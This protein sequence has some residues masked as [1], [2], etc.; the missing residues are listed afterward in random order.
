MRIILVSAYGCEPGLGSEQG[1]GWNWVLQMA[2]KN[3]VHVIT[4]ANNQS[5]IEGHLPENLRDNVIFYYY[6]TPNV[7]RKLKNRAKGLYLYY[8]FWQIGI[9]S[10]AKK[11][12][13]Q[14]NPSYIM[15]LTFGSM[16]MPTFLHFFKTPFI[17]GPVGGGDC[18]PINFF[19]ILPLKQRLQA[20]LRLSMN[21]FIC[22]NPFIHSV[23]KRSIAILCRTD[24][25][26][27]VLPTRYNKKKYTILETA[28][29]DLQGTLSEKLSK[30]CINI[31]SIGRLMPSKNIISAV[32]ALALLT[33]DKVFK[34]TIIGSGPE[35]SNIEKVI[36]ENNL[37][38]KVSIISEIPRDEIIE[39]L[40]QS[41]IFLFPSLREGGSW[42]LMEAMAMEL[43]VV[44]LNWSGMQVITDDSC[45]IRL[46]VTTPMQ[47]P[48]DMAEAIINLIDNPA[49][50]KQLGEFGRK[51]V[52]EVFNWDAKGEFMEDLLDKLDKK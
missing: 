34:Y 7:L 25:S 36:R 20:Y 4:R 28:I 5:K 49:Q 35:R 52:Q 45:A 2:K 23:C 9:I 21:K 43:P 33:N 47:M 6:D 1:V 16:W 30:N 39:Y 40:S 8:F 17:W 37:T 18:E 10:V 27:N 22:I 29:E 11:I 42:A 31:I 19:R 41:D 38:D 51:R 48:K 50:R 15:H 32:K 12:I 24:S 14:H 26:G 13:Q 44:C 3:K 46:S